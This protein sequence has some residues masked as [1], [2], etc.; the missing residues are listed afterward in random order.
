MMYHYDPNELMACPVCS[1]E[2]C[3]L[4]VEELRCCGECAA[5][6]AN[7]EGYWQDALFPSGGLPWDDEIP[8]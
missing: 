3:A 7:P 5:A 1:G 8:W 6:D 2:A 4:E